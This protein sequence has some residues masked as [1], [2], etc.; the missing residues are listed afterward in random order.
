VI[1]WNKHLGDNQLWYDDPINGTIRT[2]LNSFCLDIEG[3]ITLYYAQRAYRARVGVGSTR[4]P[5]LWASACMEA[6]LKSTINFKTKLKAVR[7]VVR[8]SRQ[9]KNPLSVEIV[10][11]GRF[12]M[13]TEIGVSVLFP[14]KQ[15]GDGWFRFSR[16]THGHLTLSR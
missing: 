13:R 1:P 8:V 5:L 3:C 6:E 2:K 9:L 14:C 16:T 7:Y 4:K 15:T 11:I 12:S 10:T